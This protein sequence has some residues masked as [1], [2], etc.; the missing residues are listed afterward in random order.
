[1]TEDLLAK[2]R[3]HS[4][5]DNIL[6]NLNFRF[7]ACLAFDFTS[8]F[9]YTSRSGFYLAISECEFAHA[10]CYSKLVIPNFGYGIFLIHCKIIHFLEISVFNCYFFSS[11][12]TFAVC[13]LAHISRD[14]Y[15]PSFF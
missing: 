3:N 1:M 14:Y 13:S 12:L 6:R 7:R 8:L 15:C 10:G 9:S 11:Y 2:I 5:F 4:D